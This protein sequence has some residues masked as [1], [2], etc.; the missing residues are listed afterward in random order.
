MSKAVIRQAAS[1]PFDFDALL[2]TPELR[3]AADDARAV[4][5]VGELVRSLRVAQGMT[6]TELA[7]RTGISQANISDVERGIGRDG[8]T[9]ATFVRLLRALG[10]EEL[11]RPNLS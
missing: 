7:E 9:V 1:K 3:R 6:Q 2:S 4:T 10:H 11:L 5:M 8:P